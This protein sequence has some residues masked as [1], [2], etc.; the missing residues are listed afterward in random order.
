MCH[1]LSTDPGNPCHICHVFHAFAGH[2][3][4][5]CVFCA[6]LSHVLNQRITSLPAP[7]RF[8]QCSWYMSGTKLK[9]DALIFK[10][11]AQDLDWPTGARGPRCRS[12]P[13]RQR[14]P[15]RI[16]LCRLSFSRVS[17]FN[18]FCF[19]RMKVDAPLLEELYLP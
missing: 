17:C 3:H 12:L 9:T 5:V 6:R 16:C 19:P 13:E 2:Y 15:K 11:L 4:E 18:E 8:G 14:S 1:G 10:L 7:R